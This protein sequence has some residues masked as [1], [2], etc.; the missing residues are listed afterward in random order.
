M[1][2]EARSLPCFQ[3]V[4]DVATFESSIG[5]V[6]LDLE[7]LTKVDFNVDFTQMLCEALLLPPIRCLK[8]L[9]V[10]LSIKHPSLFGRCEKLDALWDK[11]LNDSNIV[12][13][14]RRPRSDWLS[15]QSFVIQH[16]VTPEIAVSLGLDLNEP[17]TSNWSSKTSINFE[18]IRPVNN[19]G[20]SINR[21]ID[22]F[23]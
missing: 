10:R 6:K 15:Q 17:V 4:F 21:D 13:A 1:L 20:R 9:T 18:H 19:E 16:S 2:S 3:L 8:C 22:G 23:P 14:I 11:G 12:I 5:S 7:Y